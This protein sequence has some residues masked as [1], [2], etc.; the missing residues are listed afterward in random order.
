M[1]EA[2]I[3]ASEQAIRVAWMALYTKR[4]RIQ[5]TRQDYLERLQAHT[6]CMEQT[7]GIDKML[8]EKKVWLQEE[9]HDLKVREVVLYEALERGAHPQEDRDLLAELVELRLMRRRSWLVWWSGTWWAATRARTQRLM[10]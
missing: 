5:A 1:R 7:L 2:M 6:T 8:E 3:E 9:K 4:A 10:L